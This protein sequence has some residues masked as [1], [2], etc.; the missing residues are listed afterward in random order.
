MGGIS[1]SAILAARFNTG[2][3]AFAKADMSTYVEHISA[4]LCGYAM[5]YG[6]ELKA[7]TEL[8]GGKHTLSKMPQ[9]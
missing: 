1:T 6:A 5:I 3:L 2:T 9:T 7:D 4:S 8:G